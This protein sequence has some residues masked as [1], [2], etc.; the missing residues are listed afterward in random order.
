M[1]K[2]GFSY[3]PTTGLLTQERAGA[4]AGA[5]QES[6]K[7]Y[8][9]DA[10]GNKTS[11]ATCANPATTTACAASAMQFHPADI[12]TVVRYSRTAYDGLG[13]YP[14]ST[15]ETFWNGGSGNGSVE[16]LTQTVN[17]RDLFGNVTEAT[18]AVGAVAR[19]QYGQLGRPY[20]VWKQTAVGDTTNGTSTL[21]TY[22]L[23]GEVA[24]PAGAKFREQVLTTESPGQWTY[25]DVL[26]RPVMK[27]VETFNAGVPNKDLAVT[28]T[29]YEA[30]GKPQASSNPFLVSG[31]VGGGPS[32]SADMC[33]SG[34]S[35]RLWTTTTYDALGRP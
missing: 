16:K 7:V 12:T 29:A 10:Y 13:R 23:C 35:A 30:T 5:D 14:V 1:R 27:A 31:V 6:L 18:D 11:V 2:S 24:C 25:F 22:R 33:A 28:C 19:A 9:L 4:E 17:G 20:Q 32:V 15:T 21:T 8:G 34:N 26:G 3:A